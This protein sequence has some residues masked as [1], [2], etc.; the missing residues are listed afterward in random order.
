MPELAKDTYYIVGFEGSAD[1]AV[2]TYGAAALA[3]GGRLINA[4]LRT[5]T[6]DG[7]STEQI[8]E[9]AKD[10]SGGLQT[11]N[12]HPIPNYIGESQCVVVQV[13][14]SSL[15]GAFI[16]ALP[17]KK[18]ATSWSTE[19]GFTYYVY[20]SFDAAFYTNHVIAEKLW[21]WSHLPGLKPEDAELAN[22]AARILDHRISIAEYFI[23]E[24]V[25]FS[26]LPEDNR[27][28][29]HLRAK[30]RERMK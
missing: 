10:C 28:P 19:S 9:Y 2:V 25:D 11:I 7:G 29:E 14:T 17:D 21:D 5:G 30:I 23:Q 6:D 16:H 13:V 12:P 8:E 20:L 4:V 15:V 3:Y 26:T 18:E 27:A 1:G 22:M 24:N